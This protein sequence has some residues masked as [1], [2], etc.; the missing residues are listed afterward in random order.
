MTI[1]LSFFRSETAQRLR[2]EG[3]QQGLKEAREEGFA[4]GFAEGLTEGHAMAILLVLK[5]RGIDI[6]STARERITGCRDA[7]ILRAW[8]FRA[9][10][11]THID[12]IFVE[13]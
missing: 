10:T 2:E 11:A 4:E 5:E 9:V 3:R 7:D 1:D 13:D 8:S 12:D 6:P